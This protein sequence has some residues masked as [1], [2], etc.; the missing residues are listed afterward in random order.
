MKQSATRGKVRT[1]L[2]TKDAVKCPIDQRTVELGL[3]SPSS[4]DYTTKSMRTIGIALETDQGIIDSEI[5][6]VS[7]STHTAWRC[8]K[9]TMAQPLAYQRGQ[10]RLDG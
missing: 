3:S 6:D 8:R 10:G 5:I 1:N 4:T 2:N 7:E 9:V